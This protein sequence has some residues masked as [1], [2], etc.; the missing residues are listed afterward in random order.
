MVVGGH[1]QASFPLTPMKGHPLP[2]QQEAR[3][4]PKAGLGGLQVR[5]LLHLPGKEPRPPGR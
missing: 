1:I 2:V 4:T 3:W 5:T